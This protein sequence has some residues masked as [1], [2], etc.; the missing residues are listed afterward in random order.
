MEVIDE[1]YVYEPTIKVVVN[2]Y[3]KRPFRFKLLSV[4]EMEDIA[5]DAASDNIKKLGIDNEED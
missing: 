3:I 5:F 1:D 2:K 4:E